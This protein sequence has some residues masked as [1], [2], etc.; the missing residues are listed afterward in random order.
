MVLWQL[1]PV[2][3]L[4]G[5]L[6]GVTELHVRYHPHNLNLLVCKLPWVESEVG[7]SRVQKCLPFVAVTI[8]VGRNSR[9]DGTALG[10]V[11]CRCRR[12]YERLDPS[13]GV[14]SGLVEL[15]EGCEYLLERVL[16]LYPLGL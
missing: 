10:L 3:D 8:K 14:L 11:C 7:F 15:R 1:L 16:S 5:P 12:Q 4:F 6:L 13:R 2:K 9:A